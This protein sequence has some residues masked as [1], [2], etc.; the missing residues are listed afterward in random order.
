MGTRVIWTC[1]LVGLTP[2]GSAVAD[3]G[4][5]LL[6]NH[7]LIF[8]R[9][10]TNDYIGDGDD[11]WRTFA[12]GISALRPLKDGS[13]TEVR[14]RT[15]VIAGSKFK[16]R[17][18]EDP[19]R[20]MVGILGF[21]AY[22]AGEVGKVDY[23][24]GLDVVA[25]GPQTGVVELLGQFHELIDQGGPSTQVKALQVPNEIFLSIAGE[26]GRRFSVGNTSIR[27]WAAATGG[28]EPLA[29]MGVDLV[30]GHV[31]GG[32]GVRDEVTGWRVP[33]LKDRH[34]QGV[35]FLTG[36]DIAR[37]AK[38]AYIPND[39]LVH[40]RVR[41]RAGGLVDFSGGRVFYGATY[42]SKEFRVQ[43]EAQIVGSVTLS[44]HF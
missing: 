8:S 40:S 6:Q 2:A 29:R 30:W 17:P 23:R 39:D 36:I 31:S 16:L 32:F 15:E 3:D 33:V 9:L 13:I 18:N 12:Y 35:S 34:P 20:H 4:A 7:R 11:R 37:V 43:S 28:P 26:I 41:V 44:V 38:S 10:M 25:V 24:I 21:G 22:R 14:I 5:N 1:L 27:P 42:L 19:D